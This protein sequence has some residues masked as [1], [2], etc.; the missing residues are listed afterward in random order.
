MIGSRQGVASAMVKSS[1]AQVQQCRKYSRT[2]RVCEGESLVY[3][4]YN[5]VETDSADTYRFV[6]GQTLNSFTPRT[7][8]MTNNGPSVTIGIN[9][10]FA[11]HIVCLYMDR[12]Q[13]G[14]LIEKFFWNRYNFS[15]YGLKCGKAKLSKSAWNQLKL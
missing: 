8:T 11:A 6:R 14:T 15:N 4:E 12:S 2:V 7:I 13:D 10:E 5:P 9:I 1:S 3:G